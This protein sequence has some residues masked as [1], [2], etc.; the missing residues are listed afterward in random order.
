[1]SLPRSEGA[2]SGWTPSVFDDDIVDVDLGYVQ[3]MSPSASQNTYAPGSS[4]SAYIR[5]NVLTSPDYIPAFNSGGITSADKASSSA[6][7]IS[8]S[9]RRAIRNKLRDP[10]W[11]P[12]PRNA[13]II[14]RCDY[15]R[16]HA[17]DA[18]GQTVHAIPSDKTLSKRAAEAWKKMAEEEKAI[19]HAR[20]EAEKDEHAR[21]NPHYR[22]KPMRRPGQ[23]GST[24]RGGS[25]SRHSS[26]GG[27]RQ[28]SRGGSV[29]RGRGERASHGAS[30]RRR[31]FNCAN[32]IF[33]WDGGLSTSVEESGLHRRGRSPP[34]E[35][36]RRSSS[37]PESMV[38]E[39]DLDA[40]PPALAPPSCSSSPGPWYD[41][42]QGSSDSGDGQ[43]DDELSPLDA[44]GGAVD[45][46]LFKNFSFPS[47]TSYFSSQASLG[48]RPG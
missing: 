41:Q 21:Q 38:W 35:G 15:V 39:Q 17:R 44:F 10:T 22:F 27:S 47:S 25:T 6:F 16:E 29:S 24:S 23:Q 32:E 7:A 42:T 9:D 13:F 36:R 3:G 20:A 46:A 26:R 48:G 12:R 8:S 11:V 4:R 31:G 34:P 18:Q 45:D 33:G 1:M 43:G 28:S 2:V 19:F 5:E 14:F 37:M 40:W 30:R